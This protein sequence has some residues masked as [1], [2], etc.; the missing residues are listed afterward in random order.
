MEMF[1]TVVVLVVI[2]VIVYYYFTPEHKLILENIK[3]KCSEKDLTFLEKYT[4]PLKKTEFTSDIVFYTK[5]PWSSKNNNYIY[6]K[7]KER[8]FI[9]EEGYYYYV[10]VSENE[11]TISSE[12]YYLD[13]EKYSDKVIKIK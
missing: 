1:I 2:V 13:L 10:P 9:I 5:K 3:T 12:M 6:N 11:I 7:E 4:I 8:Y